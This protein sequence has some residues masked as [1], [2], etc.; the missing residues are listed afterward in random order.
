MD[1][2]ELIE[3]IK[4]DD[5][6]GRVQ[7]NFVNNSY[8]SV[9]YRSKEEYYTTSKKVAFVVGKIIL[10]Y[11]KT[12]NSGLTI[13]RAN[14]SEEEKWKQ[15]LEFLRQES[16]ASKVDWEICLGVYKSLEANYDDMDEIKDKS[17][18]STRNSIITK[19]N[20]IKTINKV[21]YPLSKKEAI[22]NVEIYRGLRN[23]YVKENPEL[24]LK[25]L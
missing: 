5:F 25:P 19:D 16:Q 22:R 12:L 11:F 2:K 24:E 8:Y 20:L 3:E 18:L 23:G 6:K 14:Q 7:V 17:I 4:I 21:I 15:F 1:K 10:T 9:V 13:F